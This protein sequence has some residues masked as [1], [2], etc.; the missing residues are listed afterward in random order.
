[1]ESNDLN[2][3]EIAI[4]SNIFYP[5]LALARVLAVWAIASRAYNKP[6]LLPEPGIVLKTFFNLFGE[7]YF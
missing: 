6:I 4:I 3:R 5:V 7:K 2:K 1:M